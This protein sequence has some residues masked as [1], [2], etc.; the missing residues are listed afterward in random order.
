MSKSSGAASSPTVEAQ[1]LAAVMAEYLKDTGGYCDVHTLDD[2]VYDGEFSLLDLAGVIIDTLA[3]R[4]TSVSFAVDFD[5]RSDNGPR[6][7]GPFDSRDQAMIW[8]EALQGPG[9]EASYCI[10]P[11]TLGH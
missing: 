1:R 7:V 3:G 11:I 6:L 9:W 8:A 10:V 5:Y 2:V 4:R